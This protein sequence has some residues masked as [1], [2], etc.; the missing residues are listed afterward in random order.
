MPKDGFQLTSSGY[1]AW[2]KQC[3]MPRSLWLGCSSL[4]DS[5]PSLRC[6]YNPGTGA[7]TAF[8]TYNSCARLCLNQETVC[9]GSTAMKTENCVAKLGAICA[10]STFEPALSCCFF[11]LGVTGAKLDVVAP[12]YFPLVNG[13]VARLALHAGDSLS[14]L[15]AYSLPSFSLQSSWVRGA[16]HG[17]YISQH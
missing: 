7:L 15:W 13:P 11:S 14:S 5:M 10:G 1:Q 12:F 16:V 9:L 17:N 3:S 6:L 4:A 8:Q 2:L